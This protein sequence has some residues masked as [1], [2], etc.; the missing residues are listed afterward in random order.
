MMQ[1]PLKNDIVDFQLVRNGIVGDERRGC[2]VIVGDMTYQAAK[3]MDPSVDT[4]HTALYPF[5]MEKVNN[6]DNPNVYSFFAIQLPNGQFDVIG[7]PWVNEDT[8]RTVEGRTRTYIITNFEM[9]MDGP[10]AKLL[11]DLR[12]TYTSTDVTR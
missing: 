4:K 6:V 2:T 5:F 7:L 3:M 1:P 9:R 11:R 10:I 12:A 8:F